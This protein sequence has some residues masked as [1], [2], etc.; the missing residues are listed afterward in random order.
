MNERIAAEL[1][2]EGVGE[3]GIA[4]IWESIVEPS[5]SGTELQRLGDEIFGVGLK[6]IP[7]KCAFAMKIALD[8]HGVLLSGGGIKQGI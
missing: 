4:V 5:I 3:G 7:S 6:L 2:F 1:V 8:F